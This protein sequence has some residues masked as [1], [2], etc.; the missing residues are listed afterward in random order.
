MKISGIFT[1]RKPDY[2]KVKTGDI[3][4]EKSRHYKGKSVSN[5]ADRLAGLTL[6]A[7]GVLGYTGKNANKQRFVQPTNPAHS[8]YLEYVCREIYQECGVNTPKYRYGTTVKGPRYDE[9][10]SLGNPPVITKEGY[11]HIS[12]LIP[13]DK[14]PIAQLSFLG[15]THDKSE[16]S[17]L[18]LHHQRLVKK[19]ERLDQGQKISGNLFGAHLVALLIQN[20]DM[21]HYNGYF[22]ERQNRQHFVAID[23]GQA[24]FKSS[25]G[26]PFKLTKALKS[27][28]SFE[29]MASTDQLLA[30]VAQIERLIHTNVDSIYYNPRA[31]NMYLELAPAMAE[32]MLRK[33]AMQASCT[34]SPQ[35]E[36]IATQFRSEISALVESTPKTK[37]GVEALCRSI[38]E[39]AVNKLDAIEKLPRKTQLSERSRQMTTINN[40]LFS[41]DLQIAAIKEN[42]KKIIQH[43]TE[44]YGSLEEFNQREEK[45][46]LV[47][48]QVLQRL[49]IDE[50]ERSAVKGYIIEDLR[51]S[52][53]QDYV[54]RDVA[55]LIDKLTKDFS[56]ELNITPSVSNQP[57]NTEGLDG[58]GL[59]DPTITLLSEPSLS[60]MH[61]NDFKDHLKSEVILSALLN[62]ESIKKLSNEQI[63]ALFDIVKK[64]E[65]DLKGKPRMEP[66]GFRA[67]FSRGNTLWAEVIEC[68]KNRLMENAL[69][70]R[71]LNE[72]RTESAHKLLNTH[73]TNREGETKSAQIFTQYGKH[74]GSEQA[75]EDA[76]NYIQERLTSFNYTPK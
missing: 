51:G 69:T 45:R 17:T 75:K 10:T 33:L 49:D 20:D 71:N 30:G 31:I 8:L 37:E 73:T 15:L 46:S 61:I 42:G 21:G 12:H 66:I 76:I 43:Y 53:Y 74:S 3:S 50:P 14:V 70:T 64:N 28:R 34:A 9:Q 13:R 4:L 56:S 65:E 23:M 7:G 40:P 62:K 11:A 52:Y 24:K 48:E 2:K 63:Y 59:P 58:W 32:E 1:P 57:I 27:G 35:L 19:G 55:L 67:G 39:S 26:N 25:D 22:L 47:A 68:M 72:L 36:K 44:K 16:Q 54:G 38:R 5:T 41:P 6:A 60:K 29:S 18:Y